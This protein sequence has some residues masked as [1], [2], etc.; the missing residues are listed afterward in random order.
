MLNFSWWANRKD[1][2][3]KNVFEG[4]STQVYFALHGFQALA[5]VWQFS[6]PVVSR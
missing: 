1:R 2:F 4:V 3:G 6:Q 5:S